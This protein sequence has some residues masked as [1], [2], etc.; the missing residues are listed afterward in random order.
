VERRSCPRRPLS[1]AGDRRRR[2]CSAGISSQQHPRQLANRNITTG[3]GFL[4]RE[5]GFGISESLI[6]YS[7]ADT[8]GRTFLVG[9]LN[10][11]LVAALGIVWRRSSASSSASPGCRATGWSPGFATVYVETL[12]QHPAA[13]ADL[14]LV[15]RRAAAAAAA[16]PGTR[17]GRRR[18]SSTTAA[19]SAGAARRPGFGRWWPPRWSSAS[20]PSVLVAAGRG[21]ARRRPAGGSRRSIVGAWSDPRPAAARLAGAAAPAAWEYPELTGFNFRGGLVHRRSSRR[22]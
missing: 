19:C 5:A 13:A 21:G 1:G 18:S 15:L 3:F 20:S 7:A 9:L 2:R 4:E 11:L 17:S 6:P 16:A 12:P 8:Y 10:T 14:L 22:C